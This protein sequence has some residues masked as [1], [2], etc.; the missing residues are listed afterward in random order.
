MSEIQVGDFVCRPYYAGRLES[1][2]R[3]LLPEVVVRQVVRKTPKRVF[4]LDGTQIRLPDLMQVGHSSFR[5]H[6]QKATPEE[7]EIE[8]KRAEDRKEW[9]KL[10]S[11]LDTIM[12]KRGLPLAQ[13]RAMVSAYK[14]EGG[15]L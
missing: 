5:T 6:W 12:G 11:D 3:E 8:R 2:P 4:L 15:V 1:T 7:V 14:A 13:L 10:R 9:Q